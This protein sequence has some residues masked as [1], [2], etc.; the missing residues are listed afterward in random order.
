MTT[1]TTVHYHDDGFYAH[2][3][4]SCQSCEDDTSNV[5]TGGEWCLHCGSDTCE[6]AIAHNAA[7]GKAAQ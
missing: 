1:S 7:Y 3:G 6:H 4:T 5:N 2:P